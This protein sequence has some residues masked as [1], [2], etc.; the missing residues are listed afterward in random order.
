MGLPGHQAKRV[1]CCLGSPRLSFLWV[2]LCS[3]SGPGWKGGVRVARA[4]CSTRVCPPWKAAMPATQPAVHSAFAH[5]L[6]RCLHCQPA[7]SGI[8]TQNHRGGGVPLSESPSTLLCP[9]HTAGDP[10]EAEGAHSPSPCPGSPSWPA[11]PLASHSAERAGP[12][13]SPPAHTASPSTTQ[14]MGFP[15]LESGGKDAVPRPSL[16]GC[17]GPWRWPRESTLSKCV[18]TEPVIISGCLRWAQLFSIS[19]YLERL[20][21]QLS[22]LFAQQPL[23]LGELPLSTLGGLGGAVTHSTGGTTTTQPQGGPGLKHGPGQCSLGTQSAGVARHVKA[24]R[25]P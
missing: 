19:P 25:D 18:R 15:Y 13:G 11:G 24:T 12:Q 4:K 7:L 16:N 5:L 14:S 2:S 8:P 1:P 3:S 20:A 17:K 10:G 9:A 6:A 22:V 21:G 23:F